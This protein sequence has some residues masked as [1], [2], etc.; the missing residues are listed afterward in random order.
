MKRKIASAILGLS[1][2]AGL[3]TS[4]FAG[5]VVINYES[6]SNDTPSTADRLSSF[7]SDDSCIVKGSITS[8]VDYFKFTAPATGRYGIDVLSVNSTTVPAKD[9]ATLQVLSGSNP[10]IQIGSGSIDS[11]GAIDFDVNLTGGQSYYLKLV[12]NSGT[13][14]NYDID[15]GMY[16]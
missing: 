13:S 2:I 9:S 1:L 12:K 16:Q 4:V 10:S 3:S 14:W 7:N 15:L 5:T 6:E 11:D 8:N